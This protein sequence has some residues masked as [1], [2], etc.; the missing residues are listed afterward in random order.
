[1]PS[2]RHSGRRDALRWS[3]S[4]GGALCSKRGGDSCSRWGISVSQFI[5]TVFPVRELITGY[6]VKSVHTAVLRWSA[7]PVSLCEE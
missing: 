3:A 7:D 4:N 6:F 1:M 5:K 2:V